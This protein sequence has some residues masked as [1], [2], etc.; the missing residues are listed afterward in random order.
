M[1]AP[2]P[3]FP[4]VTH[5]PGFVLT[6]SVALV[7]VVR[8]RT[9][10]SCPYDVV[11]ALFRTTALV[12]ESWLLDLADALVAEERQGA[13][14]AAQASTNLSILNGYPIAID[15]GTHIRAWGDILTLART[16]TIAVRDAAY[17]ELALRLKR[18]LATT[19][20]TLLR[21]ASAAG[22]P[23]FTP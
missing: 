14:A 21:A 8:N 7:W 22:V 16:H 10:T 19:D 1:T 4:N 17:L 11:T 5:P 18:P 2:P 12:P 15:P 3:L 20:A 13:I 9:P 23:V 6:V